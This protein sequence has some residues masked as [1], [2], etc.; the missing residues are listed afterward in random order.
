M[1]GIYEKRIASLRSA[2]IDKDAAFLIVNEVNIGYFT[3]FFHSEGALLVTEASAFLLV[4]FRYHEAALKKSH[5]CEVVCFSRMGEE[6]I[7]LMQREGLSSLFFEPSAMTY[8][9]AS[10]LSK[11]LGEEKIALAP[12]DKLDRAVEALRIIKDE[13][14][15]QKIAKAQQIAER[16]YLEVLNDL[17]PGVT[18]RFISARLE[19]LMKLYGA[20]DISFSLITITGKKTSLPHGVP[21]DDEVREGDFFTFDFGAMYEGYHSDTTRTVAIGSASDEMREIYDIVLRAQLAA[22]EKIK[23]GES[24]SVIDKT[25]RDIITEAGFGKYFGHSTGHGVGLDIHEMPY[26]SSRSESVLRAGMVITDEPGIY[27][28]DKFGVRIED[29]MAVTEDGC[30]NFVSLPKELII[31]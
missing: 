28:P 14:E 27:L 1:N 21:G 6:L 11:K 8:S 17:K 16:A 5:A 15:L 25:A 2:L 3:G 29:M 12:S 31:I 18:E 20:E 24:C 9:R 19:Y 22:L 23:A 30:R 7:G 26:V 4:D 13:S 10:A